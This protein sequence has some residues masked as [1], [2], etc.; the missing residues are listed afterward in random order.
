MTQA[1]GIDKQDIADL[2]RWLDEY[3]PALQRYALQLVGDSGLAEDLVQDTLLSAL[4]YRDTFE[5]RSKFV[6]WLKAIL[7]NKIIDHARK[8]SRLTATDFTD[9]SLY[10]SKNSPL[11][12]S[13]VRRWIETW[14]RTPERAVE[15]KAYIQ[16]LESCLA[17]LP[18]RQ[19]Q[20]L[21]AKASGEAEKRDVCKEL[22]ITESNFGVLLYR[23]RM[24]LKKCIDA[25]LEL[26]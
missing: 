15:R 14:S 3:G 4:R 13:N 7:K 19:R 20:I 1:T 17:T 23:G 11:H 10:Y 25:K 9:E 16:I 24:R 18:D 22:N 21:L 8:H 2:G 5:G 12:D 6:S 26:I